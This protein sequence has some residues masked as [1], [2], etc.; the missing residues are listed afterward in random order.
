VS[1][2]DE[3]LFTALPKVTKFKAQG[4]ANMA[5][6]YSTARHTDVPLFSTLATAAERRMGGFKAQ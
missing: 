3:K 2:P 4:I 5:W 6:A 1:F